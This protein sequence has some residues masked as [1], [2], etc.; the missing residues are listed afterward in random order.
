MIEQISRSNYSD[1]EMEQ[2]VHETVSSMK[3][4]KAKAAADSGEWKV[5]YVRLVIGELEL[6]LLDME[7]TRIS[8]EE[9]EIEAELQRLMD[10]KRELSQQQ[11]YAS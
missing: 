6:R 5:A 4:A 8:E 11:H 3:R 9:E 10:Q 7:L 1:N 2:S